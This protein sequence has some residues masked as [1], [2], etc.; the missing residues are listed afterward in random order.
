M[1]CRVSV[2]CGRPHP[3]Y[4]A[5]RTHLTPALVTGGLLVDDKHMLPVTAGPPSAASLS[6]YVTKGYNRENQYWSCSALLLR[7]LL[8]SQFGYTRDYATPSRVA[9]SPRASPPD[10]DIQTRRHPRIVVQ[11]NLHSP[12]LS[13]VTNYLHAAHR[14]D[15]SDQVKTRM[16]S[17]AEIVCTGHP[18]APDDAVDIFLVN[19][20]GKWG[21]LLPGFQKT[22]K[23]YTYP[24]H[25][26]DRPG[27]PAILRGTQC[28]IRRTFARWVSAGVSRLCTCH[29]ALLHCASCFGNRLKFPQSRW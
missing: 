2:G 17:W 26:R 29:G 16:R 4:L 9:G 23:G 15:L 27:C 20:K 19:P 25:P 10:H 22:Y 24:P 7:N 11:L 21:S 3:G 12:N 1:L 18:V 8:F 14:R 5:L 28:C 13:T 6:D